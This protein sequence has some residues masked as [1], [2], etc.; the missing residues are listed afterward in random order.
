M[1]LQDRELELNFREITCKRGV[2]GDTFA[3]GVQDFDFSVS[4]KHA[5]IPSLSYFVITSKLFLSSR[6]LLYE[7]I[8]RYY[9]YYYNYFLYY[10]N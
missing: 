8:V 5:F 6:Y 2:Q 4:G 3:G 10:F 1:N 9:N 7:F